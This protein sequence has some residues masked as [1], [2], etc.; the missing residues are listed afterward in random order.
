MNEPLERKIGRNSTT[1][2]RCASDCPELA[3]P[4][5]SHPTRRL[6]PRWRGA[7][8]RHEVSRPRR[9]QRRAADRPGKSPADSPGR[10]GSTSGARPRYVFHVNAPGQPA[11]AATAT[12]ES[13]WWGLAYGRRA[14]DPPGPA[15]ASIALRAGQTVRLAHREVFTATSVERRKKVT[16]N[17]ARLRLPAGGPGPDRADGGDPRSTCWSRPGRPCRFP[18]S[19][20]TR[21]TT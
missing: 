1:S 20:K 4:V 11:A 17:I 3:P 7:V 15:S 9:R 12:E 18:S 2:L 8:A 14:I 5:P 21:T 10:A 16:E 19:W 6:P 13:P